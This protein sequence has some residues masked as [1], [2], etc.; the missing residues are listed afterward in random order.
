MGVV[1]REFGP[2]A[3]RVELFICLSDYQVVKQGVHVGC[4]SRHAKLN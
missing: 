4:M 3:C 1:A 2:S